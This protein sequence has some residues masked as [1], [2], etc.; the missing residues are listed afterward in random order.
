MQAPLDNCLDQ[1][2][3]RLVRQIGIP[4]CP[5]ILTQLL[6]E[7]RTDDPDF[8]KIGKLIAGDVSLAASVLKIVN[9]PF[10][11]R[12]SPA[13]SVQHALML[14][15]LRNVSELITGLLLR[16]VFPV[17]TSKHLDRFWETS[18]RTAAVSAK[19]AAEL[20][21]VDRE[22][23]YTVGLFRDCGMAVMLGKFKGYDDVM[24]GAA[25]RDGAHIIDIESE[26]YE[27]SHAR[28]GFLLARSWML[29]D[30]LCAAV[31]HHHSLDALGGRRKELNTRSMQLIAVAALAEQAVSVAAGAVLHQE[32]EGAARLAAL[33]LRVPQPTTAKFVSMAEQALLQGD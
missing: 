1:E 33:Q 11:G 28:L 19:I 7:M 29:A 31:L 30:D 21:V 5:A 26:R 20:G 6:R 13:T 17:G 8:K 25:L 10:Y 15:G 14:F 24:S 2:A 9:S 18:S 27:M 3:E 23:A 16:Q 32:A 22:S 4:P 12:T